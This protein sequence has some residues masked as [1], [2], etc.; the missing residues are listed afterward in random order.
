MP[1]ACARV[2]D[3][4]S[5]AVEVAPD[6]TLEA[7]HAEPETLPPVRPAGHR[8]R[9]WLEALAVSALAS[10]VFVVHPFGFVMH[11]PYWAD[12]AWVAVLS[13]FLYALLPD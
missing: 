2:G 10:A 12:E 8:P 3:V 13:P 1:V 6:T 5:D 9:D 4:A 7:D 11:H